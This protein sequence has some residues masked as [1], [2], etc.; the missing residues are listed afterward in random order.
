VGFDGHASLIHLIAETLESDMEILTIG[1][2][3][4]SPSDHGRFALAFSNNVLEH[5]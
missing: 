4:L 2:E 3:E 1:A 5:V